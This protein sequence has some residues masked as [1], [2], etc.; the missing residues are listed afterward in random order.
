MAKLKK[1]ISLMVAVLIVASIFT[2]CGA[3]STP[4][5]NGYHSDPMM[6][7]EE[8][9][10]VNGSASIKDGYVN[11]ETK[12]ASNTSQYLSQQKLIYSCTVE[13]ET[14]TF[15]ETVKNVKDLINKYDGFIES[16]SLYDSSYGWYYSDYVKNSGTL[17]ENIVVR[18]PTENYRDFLND[19]DGNGKVINKSEKVTNITKSYNNTSTTI[20]VLEKEEDMLLEMMDKCN[21]IEEMIIVEERLSEVQRL[22]ATQRTSLSNMDIDIAFS[23]ISINIEEVV[24]YT[25]IVPADET[26]LERVAEAISDSCE[27]FVE[28]L[29]D[30]VIWLIYVIPYAIICAIVVAIIC[31]FTSKKRKKKAI[32]NKTKKNT[33]S[34]SANTDSE[35]KTD[36][37]STESKN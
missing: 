25:R 6:D 34:N 21:T 32:E 1:Y 15:D 3:S 23:T 30:L 27:S 18:V 20:E 9:Y 11:A 28:M 2:G 31:V 7:Y 14:L 10:E 13:L 4:A 17:S 22:L 26:F 19:L 8:S 36:S 35:P 33:I 16:D 12:S 29:E 5:E 24:E 37:E